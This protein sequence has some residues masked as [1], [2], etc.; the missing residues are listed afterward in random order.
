MYGTMN[1]QQPLGYWPKRDEVLLSLHARR[2][3]LTE[4]L[5]REL[6]RAMV[7]DQTN[8]HW[9]HAHIQKY[10]VYWADRLAINCRALNEWKQGNFSVACWPP[11]WRT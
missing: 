1:E 5:N 2:R 7:I 10:I 4:T 9:A 11:E 6:E 3:E 8:P